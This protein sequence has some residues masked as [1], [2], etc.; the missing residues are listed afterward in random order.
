MR[1]KVVRH[2]CFVGD[3]IIL[4][5]DIEDAVV[6]FLCVWAITQVSAAV[7]LQ[8]CRWAQ[9][10]LLLSYLNITTEKQKQKTEIIIIILNL[11]SVVFAVYRTSYK[12]YILLYGF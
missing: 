2:P 10:K 1:L 9:N 8:A 5:L 4:D 12:F 11:A 7:T 3:E 6:C